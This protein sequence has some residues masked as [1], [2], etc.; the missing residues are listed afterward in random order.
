MSSGNLRIQWGPLSTEGKIAS[1]IAVAGVAAAAVGVTALSGY[2]IGVGASAG[3]VWG[4]TASAALALGNQ[5]K[6]K[7]LIPLI[8]LIGTV[9]LA[10]FGGAFG[11]MGY[12]G[13][14][15]TSALFASAKMIVT[16]GGVVVG[17]GIGLGATV[18][19]VGGIASLFLKRNTTILKSAAN[20]DDGDSENANAN[21]G[22]NHASKVPAFIDVPPDCQHFSSE[23]PSEM[24]I[25]PLAAPLLGPAAC[26]GVMVASAS[27]TSSSR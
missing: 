6:I 7:R 1:G 27:T 9:A 11:L 21:P 10:V 23:T 20:T 4:V 26:S 19:I 5:I 2:L 17:S 25:M 8:N 3:I 15:F 24:L 18:L 16:I 22:T 14:S 13:L 12:S